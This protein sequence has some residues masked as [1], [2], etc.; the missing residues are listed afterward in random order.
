M[1]RKCSVFVRFVCYYNMIFLFRR[2]YLFFS[3]PFGLIWYENVKNKQPN[4]HMSIVAI[5]FYALLQ[6]LGLNACQ[7]V[8]WQALNDSSID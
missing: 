3:K 2:H 6:I 5:Y 1:E 4:Q 8:S 7:N